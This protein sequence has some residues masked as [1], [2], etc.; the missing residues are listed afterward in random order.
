[1]CFRYPSHWRGTSPAVLLISICVLWAN[2][3]GVSPSAIFIGAK[4]H[5]SATS[6]HCVQRETR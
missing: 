2:S 1:M 5:T 4:N 6:S 3:L